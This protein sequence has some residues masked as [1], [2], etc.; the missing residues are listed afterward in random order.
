MDR[1][2]R[3]ILHGNW[4]VAGRTGPGEYESALGGNVRDVERSSFF[5]R[6]GVILRNPEL[7]ISFRS[8]LSVK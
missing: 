4:D 3:D 7:S 2:S 1:L 6:R 5:I 8:R